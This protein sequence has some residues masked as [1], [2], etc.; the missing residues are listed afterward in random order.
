MC[1]NCEHFIFGR[2]IYFTNVG[3]KGCFV[4]YEYKNDYEKVDSTTKGRDFIKKYSKALRL[5]FSE[6]RINSFRD[7]E[8]N[9][10]FVRIV[11]KNILDLIPYRNVLVFETMSADRISEVVKIYLP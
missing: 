3:E 10:I 4:T 8:I 9:D 7:D 1:V 6:E 2:D 5:G 11:P